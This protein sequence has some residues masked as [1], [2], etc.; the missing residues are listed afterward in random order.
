MG[1]LPSGFLRLQEYSPQ[2]QQ[3]AADQQAALALQ[4]LQGTP[5]MHDPRV[6]RLSITIAQVKQLHP[7]VH[8]N[9]VSYM[10]I[11]NFLSFFPGKISKKLWDDEN[12]SLRK[13]ASRTR[14]LRNTN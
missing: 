14:S 10:R 3:E 2:Q 5:Q 8:S 6:G 9:V 12:G 1:P 13:T 7:L 4:Q 11:R